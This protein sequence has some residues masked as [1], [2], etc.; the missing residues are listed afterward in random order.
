LVDAL[1][2]A[3]VLRHEDRIPVDHLPRGAGD[4]MG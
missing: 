2:S 4:D 1:A 3:L